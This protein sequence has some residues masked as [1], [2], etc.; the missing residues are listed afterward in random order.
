MKFSCT[1]G[2]LQTAVGIAAKATS[3]K[4]PIPALEGILTEHCEAS[5]YLHLEEVDQETRLLRREYVF[6]TVEE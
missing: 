3:A 5:W 1:R 4:S 6:Q 2:E